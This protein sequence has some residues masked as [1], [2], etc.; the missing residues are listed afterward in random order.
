MK[1]IILAG[2]L[3]T[4]L[5]PLTL[6][7]NKHL[8]AL[9]DKPMILYPLETLKQAG[10]ND[11]LIVSGREHAGHFLEFLG[12][13]ADYG[14]KLTY[15]VQDQAGGI[16]HAL[17]LAEDFADR[18]AITVI[19]SDNI[20]EDN[21]RTMVHN[22]KKG[23][24][25]FLKKVEDPERFGVPE[26]KGKT[27]TKIIEK[28]TNPP[29]PY[30]VT[31]L[32]QYDSDVFKIIKKLKPSGR[33]E[34]EIT[35]VN[36]AYIRKGNMKAEFVNGFWS[37]AGTFESLARTT[38]WIMNKRLTHSTGLRVNGEPACPEFIRRAEPL[39]KNKK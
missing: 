4:R 21:F 24:R 3:G 15:K 28:P 12:S 37:D 14:V 9:Y 11:I 22:F 1:G 31:G 29:T 18:Q 30:A 20:Y 2:G 7:T 33:G 23:A 8:I 26:L 6:V 16:A 35:D 39:K 13:G 17:L 36:N 38:L 27:V 19:L 10:I 32:Y 34:L 5:R 25:I